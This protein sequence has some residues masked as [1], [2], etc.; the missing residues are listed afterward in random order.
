VIHLLEEVN[1]DNR[2]ATRR[3]GYR[4]TVNWRDAIRVQMSELW[5]RQQQPMRM[6]KPLTEQG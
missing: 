6:N 4:P 5:S 2:R 3:L 1:V